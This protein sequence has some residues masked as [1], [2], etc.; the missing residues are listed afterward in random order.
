MPSLLIK[1]LLIPCQTSK[2]VTVGAFSLSLQEKPSGWMATFP[3]SLMIVCTRGS[4]IDKNITK[5]SKGN[6]SPQTGQ[7]Q[8]QS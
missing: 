2:R 4:T 7:L 1:V 5:I 8:S 6:T 3:R